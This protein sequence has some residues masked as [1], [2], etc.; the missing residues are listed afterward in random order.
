MITLISDQN[1][2]VNTS[3]YKFASYPFEKF[4]PVQSRV[5][6]YYDKRDNLL[7]AAA[8]SSG[9]T[10][11][12]ELT[13]AYEIRNNK[14]KV[15]YLAPLRSLALEKYDEWTDKNYHFKDIQVSI[16]TGDFRYSQKRVEELNNSDLIIMTS[17]ALNSRCRNPNAETSQ[18]LK[19]I[20]TVVIDESHLLTVPGRG[21]HLENAMVNLAKVSPNIRFV[22]LSATLPNVEEV[23]SWI[24]KL[25]NRNT[26]VIRSEYRPCKLNMH[27]PTYKHITYG[28]EENEDSK[29]ARAV[30]II[31]SF[32]QDK[33]LIFA[34]TKRTGDKLLNRL[35]A[36]NIQSGFHNAD[37]VKDDR[38]E[39][40]TKFKTDPKFRTLIATSTIAWG[41]YES[42]SKI[43]MFDGSYK[44]ARD[45][46]VNDR[47]LSYDYK[48]LVEGIVT[49][50]DKIKAQLYK[51]KLQ[52]GQELEVSYNHIFYAQPKDKQDGFYEVRSLKSGDVL[53]KNNKLNLEKIA[54]DKIEEFEIGYVSQI[55]VKDYHLLFGEEIL[56]HNCNLPARRVIILGVH[57]GKT[58]VEPYDILQMCIGLDTKIPT[59]NGLI[60]ASDISIGQEVFAFNDLGNIS[61]RK[62]LNIYKTKSIAKKIHFSN[63]TVVTMSN[64]PVF[65][66][67]KKWKNSNELEIGDKVCVKFPNEN[68]KLHFQLFGDLHYT[69]VDKIENVGETDLINF[70]VDELNTFFASDIATHNCGRAGRPKYDPE[71]D[72][73]ILVPD[74]YA[75]KFK[76][77]ILKQSPIESQMYGINTLSFHLISE[78][79][80][81]NITNLNDVTKWYENLFVYSQKGPAGLNDAL[82]AIDKL[83]KFNCVKQDGNNLSI[84]P[85]GIVASL[86]YFCPF[87]VAQWVKNLNKL[88]SSKQEDNPINIAF[89]LACIPTMYGINVAGNE[90]E[91]ISNWYSGH[92]K[93]IHA[94]YSGNPGI[95]GEARMAYVLT[96]LYDQSEYACGISIKGYARSVKN[97]FERIVEMLSVADYMVGKWSKQEFWDD[98]KSR[99]VQGIESKFADLAKLD[100]IGKV[101]ANRLYDV[102]IKTLKDIVENSDK[103]KN[104]LKC[105][106]KVLQK[107]ISDA[108]NILFLESMN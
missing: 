81:E 20:L 9:K 60:N 19:K 45:I 34:H 72:C 100:G 76:D 73:H 62:I 59:P 93:K 31:E 36:L 33:F 68:T 69:F 38:I 64:H 65:T 90:Q 61:S 44:K 78:I 107:I 7:I 22:L 42:N 51:V 1:N 43:A 86:Y 58:E 101:K 35:K 29:I 104:T 79:H 3:E 106:E 37:L 16:I 54:I 25:T 84:A 12:S 94:E 85:L 8:T 77:Q 52:N 83:V 50:N 4:N 11:C 70:S 18:F 63:G 57:R 88:F 66:W 15:L 10:V 30:Q 17:E 28:Y 108:K 55:A 39:L 95:N 87:D 74:L 5:F 27:F 102:N 92:V 80:H 82:S 75:Q 21:D 41:C 6:E 32:P 46:V 56:S 67:N 40:E 91:E 23:A 47:I 24:S 98:I 2:L 53:F 48:N 13:A 96:R 71:G 103:V 14:N 26:V 97:D 105:S 99:I 49:R 89:A